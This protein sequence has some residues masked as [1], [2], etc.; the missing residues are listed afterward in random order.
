MKEFDFAMVPIDWMLKNTK[1]MDI[2][3]IVILMGS[4]IIFTKIKKINYFFIAIFLAIKFTF[5]S[6]V[7]DYIERKRELT[8]FKETHF[9]SV[10]VLLSL[11]VSIP[12]LLLGFFLGKHI[13]L[14]E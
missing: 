6:Y 14:D 9:I 10:K 11:I 5:S 3:I 12:F 13:P 4:F 1:V 7:D 2:S 8:V